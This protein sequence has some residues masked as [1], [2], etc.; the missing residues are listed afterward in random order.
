MNA[1]MSNDTGLVK[2]ARDCVDELCSLD[3][4]VS[5]YDFVHVSPAPGQ[6]AGTGIGRGAALSAAAEQGWRC[7][8]LPQK[9]KQKQVNA[10]LM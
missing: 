10:G 5:S 7:R 3:T 9:S 2:F 8:S 1:A 6:T 4:K